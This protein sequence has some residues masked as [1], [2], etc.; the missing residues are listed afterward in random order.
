VLFEE[1]SL[2]KNRTAL[3]NLTFHCRLHGLP[4]DHAQEIL[5]EVGLADHAQG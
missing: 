2:Y 4:N 3:A 1:N 5:A